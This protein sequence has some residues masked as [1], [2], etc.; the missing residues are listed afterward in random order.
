MK[1]G[2]SAGW[3]DLK[4]RAVAVRA[5]IFGRTVEIAVLALDQPGFRVGA[6][7]I[8]LSPRGDRAEGIEAGESA[9]CRDLKHRAVAVRA[10]IFGRTVE[11]AVCAL[12]QPASR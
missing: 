6:I 5:A 10:A 2:Q 8:D 7:H 3:R 11:I 12:D 1:G 4:H 9:G